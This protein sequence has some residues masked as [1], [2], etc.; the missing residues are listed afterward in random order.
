K[1]REQKDFHNLF[2]ALLMKKRCQLGVTPVPTSPALK[3]PKEVHREYEDAIRDAARTVGELFLKEGNI[4]QAYPYFNMIQDKEPV[5]AA[6][7][8]FKPA[9]GDDCDAIVNIAYHQAVNPRR[10]FDIILDRFGICSAI[11]TLGG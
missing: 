11:T 6:L 9:E 7:E 1:L 3:L 8:K 5:I 4:P 2:Y 10:G